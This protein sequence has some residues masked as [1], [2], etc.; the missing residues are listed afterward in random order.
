MESL[1]RKNPRTPPIW[2]D[3]NR[4]VFGVGFD[5]AR[6][7]CKVVAISKYP[8]V[9]VQ[10]Y[11]LRAPFWRTIT[12]CNCEE[13]I[14]RKVDFNGVLMGGPIHWIAQNSGDISSHM[15]FF[16][17]NNE[18]FNYI[19]LPQELGEY[20]EHKHPVM[21]RGK[22]GL[23]HVFDRHLCSLWVTEEDEAPGAWVKLYEVNIGIDDPLSYRHH[24]HVLNFKENGQLIFA[25]AKGRGVQLYDFESREMKKLLKTYPYGMMYSIPYKESSVLI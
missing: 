9:S 15:V 5:A 22:L 8:R 25:T 12:N 19:M 11:E 13:S 4:A 18:V 3:V 7:D 17:L 24:F 16:D 21:Y 10:V 20:C 14:I 6:N 2:S 23:L 1:V